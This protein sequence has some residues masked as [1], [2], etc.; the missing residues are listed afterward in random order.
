ME[1]FKLDQGNYSQHHRPQSRYI[2]A[3]LYYIYMK[4]LAPPWLQAD[5]WI[6]CEAQNKRRYKSS[7]L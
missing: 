5:T 3:M 6:I 4:I 7:E 1:K 2:I